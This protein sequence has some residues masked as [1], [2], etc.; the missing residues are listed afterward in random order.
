[1]DRFGRALLLASGFLL[2][3]APHTAAQPFEQMGIRALGMAG[4][5]VG[6]ADDASAVWWNPAALASGP[7]FTMSLEWQGRRRESESQP[8]RRAVDQTLSGF[9]A[10]TPPLGVSYSRTRYTTAAVADQ[11]EI[12]RQTSGGSHVRVSSLVAHQTGITLLHSLT[13]GLVVGGTVK[14]VR[15]L[16]LVEAREALTVSE[17]LDEAADLIGRGSTKFDADLGVHYHAGSFR[18][19][20]TVQHLTE[21]GFAA[22][23]GEELPLPRQARAGLAWVLREATT[24]AAD[25]DLTRGRDDPHGRRLALGVEQRWHPRLATRAGVNVGTGDEREPWLALGGSVAVRPGLWVDG[26]W[27]R[28]ELSE[29]RWGVAGRLA[30]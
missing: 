20:L 22:P 26:F 6:V 29:S 15:G 9:S 4:A 14:V 3:S 17:A 12:D 5:F 8:G 2:T 18:T 19:G 24:L 16:A 10:A 21:P 7:F 28:G 27:S 23:S 11:P 13:D 1:M 30:Y 25:L